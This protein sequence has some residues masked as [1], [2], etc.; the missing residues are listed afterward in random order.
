MLCMEL[1]VRAFVHRRHG[2]ERQRDYQRQFQAAAWNA[3]SGRPGIRRTA[4]PAAAGRPFWRR[5][6]FS[7]A[8]PEKIICVR[9]WPSSNEARSKNGLKPW[10]MLTVGSYLL[11]LLSLTLPML[12]WSFGGWLPGQDSITLKE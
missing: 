8:T 2:C 5:T 1:A 7:G 10:A 6:G 12:L 4:G 11:L 3:G 9:A